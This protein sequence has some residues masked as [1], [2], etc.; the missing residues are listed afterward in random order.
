MFVCI[1][2]ENETK[3]NQNKTTNRV[4]Y[5]SQ[6]STNGQAKCTEANFQIQFRWNKSIPSP[7]PPSSAPLLPPSSSERP[8]KPAAVP[9][10]LVCFTVRSYLLFYTSEQNI[11][12]AKFPWLYKILP[13]LPGWGNST[14]MK[15]INGKNEFYIAFNKIAATLLGYLLMDGWIDGTMESFQVVLDKKIY[16]MWSKSMWCAFNN[17]FR[18]VW[19]RYSLQYVNYS[20]FV[21]LYHRS[22][23]FKT[24][25]LKLI[26]PQ[27]VITITLQRI[28]NVYYNTRNVNSYTRGKA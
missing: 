15:A 22:Q 1:T 11:L 14:F 20:R 2:K 26:L 8:T 5:L 23:T 18:Q 25:H 12:L 21:I 28:S 19:G 3:Q 6:A 17:Y 16:W 9:A 27:T 10:M 7:I 4:W 24:S 13:V